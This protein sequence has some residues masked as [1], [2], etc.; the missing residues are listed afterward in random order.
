MKKNRKRF[1]HASNRRIRIDD[2]IEPV[3]SKGSKPLVFLVDRPVFHYTLEHDRKAK[4][5]HGEAKEQS[6]VLPGRGGT[7]YLYE[8]QPLGKVRYASCWDEY[9][10]E[11]PCRVVRHIK[12]QRM[13]LPINSYEIGERFGGVHY[14]KHQG[15]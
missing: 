12:S 9:W 5:V 1:Y 8:V 14:K 15:F 10:T 13:N 7:L 11:K 6:V 4:D 2:F 3:S